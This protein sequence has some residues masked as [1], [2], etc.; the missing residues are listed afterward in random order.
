MEKENRLKLRISRMFRSS[1]GSCRPRN[2]SD[3]AERTVFSPQKPLLSAHLLRPTA[4]DQRPLPSLCRPTCPDPTF[5]INPTCIVS[6]KK[7]LLPRRSHQYYSPLPCP[8]PSPFY[9]TTPKKSTKTQKKKKEKEKEKKKEKQSHRPLFISTSSQ[10][11]NTTY[12]AGNWF[13]SD[14]EREEEDD[15][16]YWGDERESP[17]SSISLSSDDSS[18]ARRRRHRRRCSRRLSGRKATS[19]RRKIVGDVPA[20]SVHSNIKDSFAVVKRSSDP[21]GDFRTSMVEMIVE[22]QLFGAEELQRL[23]QCFLAL[24]S[25]RHHGVIVEVFTEIWETL[26][27]S[28]PFCWS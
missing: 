1:F 3:V 13:S 9:R 27:S 10:D 19:S 24:N 17:F 2:L 23:L 20:E 16:R 15:G 5:S 22:R 7:D 26:F 25:S 14:D 6:A 12:G 28:P 21:Y 4:A 18:A 8:A 11:T